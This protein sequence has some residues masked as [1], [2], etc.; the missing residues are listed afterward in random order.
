MAKNYIVEL[1]E[2]S[3]TTRYVKMRDVNELMDAARHAEAMYAER[4]TENDYGQPNVMV[5]VLSVEED[6]S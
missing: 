5:E 2:T 1:R 6:E 4:M 3:V